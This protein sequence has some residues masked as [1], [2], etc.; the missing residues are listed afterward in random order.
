M[1]PATIMAINNTR[2]IHRPWPSKPRA[3]LRAGCLPAYISAFDQSFHTTRLAY[4]VLEN[5]EHG[6]LVASDFSNSK[7][8]NIA[9]PA[10]FGSGNFKAD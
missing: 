4:R 7:P 2:T 8:S 6:N 1:S 10:I 9:F 3:I 5:D